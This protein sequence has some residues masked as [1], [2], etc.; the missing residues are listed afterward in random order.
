MAELPEEMDEVVVPRRHRHRGRSA[1]GAM[2]RRRSSR[3][4]EVRNQQ[5]NR[6]TK[7]VLPTLKLGTFNGSTCLKTFFAKFEDCS[8]YY[9]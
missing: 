6:H 3:S 4:D 9:E 5:S 8:D 2:P 1:R 7:H